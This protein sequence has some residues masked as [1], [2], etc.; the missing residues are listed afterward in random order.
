VRKESHAL[1]IVCVLLFTAFSMTIFLAPNVAAVSKTWTTDTDFNG[2]GAAFT[3]TGV[4]GTGVAASV[5]LLKD[6]TDWKNLNPA[7]PPVAR[8][9]PAAAFSTF[10]NRMVVFG[11]YNN[12]F[13]SELDDTWEYDYPTNTWTQY[14]INP[15]PMGRAYAL[16]SYDPVQQVAV[17]FAGVNGTSTDVYLR[18]TWEYNVNSRSW[19]ETNA[20]GPWMVSSSMTYDSVA[21]LHILVGRNYTSMAFQTFAYDAAANTWALKT[22]GGP[23]SRTGH[24][25]AYDLQIQRTV[26]FGGF[27]PSVPP[28]TLLGDT[29]EFDSSTNIWMQTG[30]SGPEARQ[31][32]GMTY[33][34]STTSVLMFGGGGGSGLLQDTQRYTSAH[35]WEPVPVNTYPPGRQQMAFTFDPNSDVA[36]LYGGRGVGSA[37]LGDTWS[38]EASY[39]AAG[40]YSSPTF[41][42]TCGNVDWTNLSWNKV[43]QPPNTFLRFQLATAD[44][45]S[46]PWTYL[47]PG[48]SGSTYYTITP[49]LIWTG[50]DNHRYLRFLGDFGS[51]DT[52]ATPSLEDLTVEY[53]CP[54][55]PPYIVSTDPTNTQRNVPLMQPVNVTFSKEMDPATVTWQWLLPAAGGPVLTAHWSS[56]NT[57]LSLTHTQAFAENAVYKIQ[58]FGKDLGGRDLVA[59]P[60]DPLIVNPW[61]FFTLA[62]YPYIASTNPALGDSNVA[63]TAPII[64]D[65]S[66]PMNTTS[67]KWTI[68]PNLTLSQGWTIG[69]ARLTLS[70]TNPFTQCIPYTVNITQGADKY[71][72][73]L[74]PGSKPNPWSFTIACI[75]PYMTDV[76]PYPLMADVPLASPIYVN[77]S[78]TM[79]T[80]TVNITI[81]PPITLTRSWSD[82][83]RRLKLTHSNFP[84]CTPYEVKVAGKDLAG[85]D[86]IPGPFPGSPSNPWSFMTLCANPFVIGTMPINGTMNVSLSQSIIIAFSEQ[87]NNATVKWTINPPVAELPPQW[88]YDLMLTIDHAPFTECTHY[89][90]KVTAGKSAAGYNLVPGPAPNP[91]VFDTICESPYVVSTVPANGTMLVPLNQAIIVNFSEAMNPGAFLFVLTP[92][93]GGK[94]LQWS[95]G[96]KTLTVTHTTDFSG[97]TQYQA[98]VD[99]TG[100]DGHSL[101]V[102]GPSVPDPW[103]FTTLSPG[104]Y[105]ASTNPADKAVD[106]P[107]NA[108][109]TVIFSQPAARASLSV[110]LN[111]TINPP[112][113]PSW[114]N[115]D[116]TVTLTH[117]T[118]FQECTNYTVTVSATDLGGSPL[119]TVPGSAANPW[120]FKTV[121]IPPLTPPGGLQVTRLPGSIH[122]SWRAVSGATSYLIHSATSKFTPWP[123][124]QLAMVNTTTYDNTTH[125]TDGLSHFYIVRAKS[126]TQVSGN[127]TMGVKVSITFP[128][129]PAKANIQWFSLPYRSAYTKASDISNEHTS[130]FIFAVA[131]WN[132][133]QQRPTLWYYFRTKWRGTDFTISPGDGLYVGVSASFTWVIAGTDARADLT[134]NLNSGPKGNLNWISVPYTATYASASDIVTHIEGSIGPGAHTKITEIAKWDAANQT[135][136]KFAWTASGWTGTNFVINPGDGIYLKIIASFTWTPRLITPEV[137]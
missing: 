19:S 5:E 58:I 67:V 17:L 8:E 15:H 38:L 61:L 130:A 31:S 115:G 33:R 75:N 122:L 68:N 37:Q 34:P 35:V 26:L 69:D 10:N 60:T 102:P 23:I 44:S 11:G 83:D 3:A 104:F 92:D 96:F 52:H 137:P 57:M 119:I 22:T 91:F 135:L 103:V 4:V 124:P 36:I 43:S 85:N 48:G 13:M 125:R 76:Y 89:T 27:D 24:A 14:S 55:A 132:P 116:R 112:L 108:S 121:C 88:N 109:I 2:P 29:W 97:A 114:S 74:L 45:T 46:G 99:G 107:V 71:G 63:L 100:A 39:R 32:H 106:V 59:N 21:K 62:T 42:S 53:D 70:H 16:M 90:V 47:G 95:N 80:G 65:F 93:V 50:A 20:N 72:L 49:S 134:F 1:A 6:Y 78:K 127:S 77:F 81:T 82:S 110:T 66:E 120:K 9:G 41:D 84:G 25:V 113:A 12:T 64:V 118:L 40:K 87:M 98:Y 7:M 56:G 111:P 30:T 51:F 126:A 28:G 86:L 79:N 73:P 129:D 101:L 131:K 54:I 133:S 18:D 136:L 117:T 128:Y 123:W 94:S 105:I